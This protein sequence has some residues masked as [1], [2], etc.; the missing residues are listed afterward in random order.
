MVFSPNLA[1]PTLRGPHTV[2]HAQSQQKDEGRIVR[3]P[4]PSCTTGGTPTVPQLPISPTSTTRTPPCYTH[5]S[6]DP[7]AAFHLRLH[8]PA[9]TVVHGWRLGPAGD[10]RESTGS[11]GGVVLRCRTRHMNL[12]SRTRFAL[13]GREGRRGGGHEGMVICI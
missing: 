10:I 7:G 1:F 13:R 11:H 6:N 9:S 2:M 12:R 4:S 3:R 8:S 5:T